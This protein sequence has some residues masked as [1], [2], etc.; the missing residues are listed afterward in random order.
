MLKHGYKDE[1][2]KLMSFHING[3]KLLEKHKTI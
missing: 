2:H 1:N 3:E